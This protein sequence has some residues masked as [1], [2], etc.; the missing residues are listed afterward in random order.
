M[1]I[2]KKLLRRLNNICKSDCRSL[3]L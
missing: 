3:Y 1:N 2:V